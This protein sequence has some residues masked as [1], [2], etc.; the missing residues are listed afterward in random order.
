M[1]MSIAAF[2]FLYSNQDRETTLL[3][4]GGQ[5]GKEVE[6]LSLSL[7]NIIQS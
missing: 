2:L 1:S 4:I 3:S 7:W 5:M 6:S